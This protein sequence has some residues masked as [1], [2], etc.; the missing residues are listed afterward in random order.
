MRD[1]PFLY[2]ATPLFSA[3]AV[4]DV[5]GIERDFSDVAEMLPEHLPLRAI[6]SYD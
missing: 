2:A 4:R 1:Y 5:A 6:S 3:L